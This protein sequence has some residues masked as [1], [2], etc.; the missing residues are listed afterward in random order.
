MIATL[1]PSS[2]RGRLFVAA[3]TFVL[4]VGAVSLL[5]QDTG[6]ITGMVTS[7]QSGEGLRYIN[8]VVKGTRMGAASQADGS[9]EIKNVPAGTYAL[10]FSAVG[11]ETTVVDNVMVT[12]GATATADAQ[13]ADK[14]VVMGDVTVYGASK[15]PQRLTEAPAAVNAFTAATLQRETIGGQVPTLL[16]TTPGVDV[17]TSNMFDINVNTRGFNSSLNRRVLILLDGRE[18]SI[19]FLSATRWDAF[20]VP[21]EDLG[22]LEIV[23]G[24]GSALF[25]A[26]AYAGVINITTP[27]PSAIAGTKFSVGGGELSMLR[28]DIR[29][30][31]VSGNWG[32]KM[33]VGRAQTESF[34]KSRTISVEYAGLSKERASLDDGKITSLY[35]SARVDRSLGNNRFLVFEGGAT[36]TENEVFVTGIGR[37]QVLEDLAPWG[38]ANFASDRFFVQATANGRS[39]DDQKALASGATLKE[40]SS[41]MQGEFQHNTTFDLGGKSLRLVWGASH[42]IQNV[43]TEGTLMLQK[44]DENFSG[45][46]GQLQ[47]A[48]S[49]KFTIVGASRYD[50]SSLYD[51]EFSPKAGI[52][53]SPSRNHSFRATYNKAFQSGN[54]SE[55]FLHA[56]AGA[57]VN[58]TPLGLGVVPL[59]AKGN[60]KLEVEE[61]NGFDI[62]YK[63]ILANKIYLTIDA[64]QNNLT[65]FITDLLPGVN[66]AEYP[67]IFST[68]SPQ[69]QAALNG[70]PA[71]RPLLPGLTK[72]NGANAFVFSYTNAGEVDE[73]GVELGIHYYL[74][75]EWM[76][77]ANAT[78]FDFEVKSQQLGDK[79][80]PNTPDKKFNAGIAYSGPKINASLRWRHVPSFDWAAGIFAGRIKEFDVF[81]AALGYRVNDNIRV[82]VNA[83]NLTDEKHYEVFGGSLLGRRILG[84]VQ[85][86]F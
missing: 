27:A 83:L 12:A 67:S 43:D 60:S 80:L 72:V 44:V 36:K 14:L 71:L 63:G 52:V 74:T 34:A 5:A 65:N 79:L 50:R 13:L 24:P 86:T 77:D 45:V 1:S 59:L 31:G 10:T 75:K 37:V 54:Y 35:G 57:P 21:L 64:Y 7:A 84:N 66:Q 53:F 32:Y 8:V 23:R 9:Y 33:N 17:A 3:V 70:I 76:V 62:G 69:Q 38:R 82:G 81:H 51:A 58:L 56:P 40:H 29:H 25:G 19:P 61:V 42:R 55:Y 78:W 48:L 28:G 47:L 85:A 6:T 41:T 2:G 46:Y 18:M 30:A 20:S 15:F 49:N 73:K 4:A 11:Y 26:N 68:L 16:E 22:S 39:T